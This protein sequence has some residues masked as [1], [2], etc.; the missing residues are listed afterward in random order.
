MVK[1]LL[2]KAASN[3]LAMGV[4]A[5][6]VIG[7]LAVLVFPGLIESIG[8]FFTGEITPCT[9]TPYNPN[10]FCEEG[11]NKQPTLTF[12]KV[13]CES[14]NLMFDPLNPNFESTT[15]NYAK[16]YLA[17]NFPECDSIECSAPATLLF[18]GSVALTPEHRSFYFKCRSPFDS[19]YWEFQARLENGDV[20]K[21]ICTNIS[22]PNS[23]EE[24]KKLEFKKICD[25]SINNLRCNKI[26]TSTTQTCSTHEIYPACDCASGSQC[27]KGVG[28]YFDSWNTGTLPGWTG[29]GY[30]AQ[31][32]WDSC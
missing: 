1:K 11:F 32:S 28:Y 9:D 12:G 3:P 5:V 23:P 8:A 6:V 29:C 27:T 24:E 17:E 25:E 10:C 19:D 7:L 2:K 22:I 30:L 15:L 20:E 14:D 18:N 21:A 4:V 13:Y 31:K 26:F 16:S